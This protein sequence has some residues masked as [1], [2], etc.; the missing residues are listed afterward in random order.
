MVG[1]CFVAICQKHD[2]TLLLG[3]INYEAWKG[4][5]QQGQTGHRREVNGKK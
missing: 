2:L 3:D 1:P 5:F 4:I